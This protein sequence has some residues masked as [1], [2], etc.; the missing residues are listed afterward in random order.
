LDLKEN[1]TLFKIYAV[2]QFLCGLIAIYF[3]FLI[4]PFASDFYENCFIHF[5]LGGESSFYFLALLFLVS[6]ILCLN[7]KV[8]MASNYFIS[9]DIVFSISAFF[10]L[11]PYIGTS[12]AVI[13]TIVDIIARMIKLKGKTKDLLFQLFDNLGNRLLRFSAVLITANLVNYNFGTALDLRK[14]FLTGL[15]FFIPYFIVNNLFYLPSEIFKGNKV[16][17]FFIDT[18]K[19]DLSHTL[20]TFI[21]ALYLYIVT[22]KLSL[23]FTVLT[24]L[25]ILGSIYLIAVIKKAHIELRKRIEGLEILTTVSEAASSGLDLLPM[26]EAF[27]RK[28]CES[29]KADGIGVVFCQPYSTTLNAVQVEGEKSRT[30]QLPEEEKRYQYDSLPLSEP[31]Y[32]LGN[33]LYEFLQPLET[34][35]FMIP[36][37]SYGIPLI[38]RGE[39]IG[40]VVVYSWNKERDFSSR[41]D[42]LFDCTHALVVGMENC[43]LH[44]QAIEDPLTGLF[45]RSYFLYR[46]REELS[47]S[48]RHRSDFALLMM[49]LDDF[50]VVN[51]HLGHQMGD[52]VLKR[53]GEL[54]RATLRKEDVP[55]RYGGDEFIILLIDCDEENAYEKALK[56]RQMIGLKALPKEKS[57]GLNLGCSISLVS[58]KKFSFDRDIF[59]IIKKL[60][61]ALYKAKAEG[62]NGVVKVTD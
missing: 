42:L 43:F 19:I 56:I 40:G 53:I 4:S 11:G 48:T 1:K 21:L 57:Q 55:A 60:D 9:F 30:M 3:S 7:F 41:E 46:L 24:L 52:E 34:A 37:S 23:F 51:D 27:A 54:L 36:P 26:V 2:L 45:N 15:L 62:K 58:S 12:I 10:I 33:S 35:P 29:L 13:T 39:P 28:L 49:D 44:L 14:H 5:G 25:M 8:V 32:K 31:S 16:K 47:Y 61:T 17:Q 18:F 6:S 22:L 38:Y 20:L 50:K 59:S